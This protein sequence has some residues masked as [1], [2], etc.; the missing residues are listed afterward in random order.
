MYPP[1]KKNI[2]LW[3]KSFS[4]QISD[5]EFF[6]AAR[7]QVEYFYSSLLLAYPVLETIKPSDLVTKL[8]ILGKVVLGGKFENTPY[9]DILTREIKVQLNLDFLPQKHL[10]VRIPYQ[11]L[12]SS[13]AIVFELPE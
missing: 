9:K 11:I 1:L 6:A 4:S 13:T 8:K 10:V 3:E 2:D 12:G 5:E 7:E